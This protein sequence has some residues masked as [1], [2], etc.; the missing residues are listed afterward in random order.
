MKSE[1]SKSWVASKKPSKQIKYRANAPLHIKR[2][3]LSAHLSKELRQK[4]EKRSM[5]VRKGDKVIVQRGTHKGKEG[6]IDSVDTKRECVNISG[7]DFVKKNGSKAFYPIK[8]TNIMI[9]D[10]DMSDKKRKKIVE[11]KEKAKSEK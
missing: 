8:I 11:R 10:L 9:K 1:F 6:S 3:M 5:P 4:Y 7:I 2:K